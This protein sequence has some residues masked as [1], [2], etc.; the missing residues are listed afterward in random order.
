MRADAFLAAAR[1]LPLADLDTITGGRA[2]ILAPHPDDESLG[3]GGLIAAACARGQPPLVAVLTDGTGSHPGSRKFPPERLRQ[4]REA[5]MLAA[6]A[7]LGLAAER[8]VFLRTQDTQAPQEGRAL[9]A[10]VHRLGGLVRDHACRSI[11]ATWEADPHCDHLAAHRAAHATAAATGIPHLAY[12]VWG[13]T[14]PADFELDAP[15]AGWRLDIAPHQAAKRRAIQCHQ[16]QY[17][18]LI[19]DD[20]ASF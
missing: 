5:E 13:L 7:E 15:P 14:L 6:V 2:L 9:D 1:R 20:P 12:P 17:G 11:V 10:V 4:T 8:V 18:G 16:S 3:C 19:D